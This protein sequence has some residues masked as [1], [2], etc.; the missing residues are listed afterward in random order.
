MLIPMLHF[1]GNCANAISLYEKAFNTKASIDY[2]NDNEI[3]WAEMSIHGQMVYLND[4]HDLGN[5][6]K[7][8][9]GTVHLMVTF[10][11]V[12]ELLT[13]YEY[14]KN[15]SKIIDPFAEAPYAQLGGNFLDDFG[16]L[17]CFIV[18]K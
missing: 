8:L 16:V 10:E 7:T 18:F 5:K 14:F 11:T 1:C 12:D 4:R 15:N 3:R 9:D 2:K 13:C 17:W 6:N